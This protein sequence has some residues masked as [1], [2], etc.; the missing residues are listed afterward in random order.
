MPKV[1]VVDDEQSFRGMIGSALESSGFDVVELADGR[2]TLDILE[3]EAPDL[4]LVDL[5]MPKMDGFELIREIRKTNDRLPIIVIS[6]YI[7][8]DTEEI[9]RMMGATTFLR[10]PLVYSDLLAALGEC[11]FGV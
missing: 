4:L 10:K 11:E 7:E 5:I 1:L 9:I 6:G 8:R 2:A 3:A